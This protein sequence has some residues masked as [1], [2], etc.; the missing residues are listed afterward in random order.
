MSRIRANPLLPDAGKG[1]SS[2]SSFNFASV[3]ERVLQS[4]KAL[5]MDTLVWI[6]GDIL[7]RTMLLL[8]LLDDCPLVKH[9][10]LQPPP[11]PYATPQAQILILQVNIGK[12]MDPPAC[13]MIRSAFSISCSIDG[14]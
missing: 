1:L 5:R 11:F 7:R 8:L 10:A 14:E 9:S 3:S 12:A 2:G 4:V 6:A 13:E